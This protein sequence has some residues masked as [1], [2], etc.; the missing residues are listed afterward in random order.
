MDGDILTGVLADAGQVL[1]D[2]ALAQAARWPGTPDL[3]NPYFN[4]DLARSHD[5]SF[6]EGVQKLA[7]KD[8]NQYPDDLQQV[9][10]EQW[11]H[12]DLAYNDQ[13]LRASDATVADLF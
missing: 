10:W 11:P 8:D 13:S 12:A 2:G 6:R 7:L 4:L 9:H 3:K 1:I 5:A